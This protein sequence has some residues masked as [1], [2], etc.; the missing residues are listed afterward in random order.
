MNRKLVEDMSFSQRWKE[1]KSNNRGSSLALVITIMAIVGILAAVLLSVSLATF[2]MKQT[3]MGSQKNFYDAESVMDDIRVGL[4]QYVADAAGAA[5]TWTL[6]NYSNSN[7]NQRKTNY[8]LKFQEELLKRIQDPSAG[9]YSQK[10]DIAKLDS[11]VSPAVK[12]GAKNASSVDIP[13]ISSADGNF[14][15]NQDVDAGTYTIK[16]LLVRYVDDREYMTEIR[17]D[18]VLSCPKI[19]FTQKKTE[20]QELSTYVMVAND[21]TVVRGGSIH[22]TGNAYLG[23][24]G[25]DFSVGEVEFSPTAVNGGG[26]LVTSGQLYARNGAKVNV[27]VGYS[28]WAHE[29]Y[30]D[31]AREVSVNGSIYLNDDL[32]ISNSLGTGEVKVNLGGRLYAYGNALT[33]GNADAFMMNSLMMQDLMDHPANYSSAILINGRN[34]TLDMSNLEDM[35]IAGNAYVAAGAEDVSNSD[36]RMGE[37][38]A[39]KAS[40]R[41]YL[42]PAG[43]IAPYCMHGGMNPMSADSYNALQEEMRDLLGYGSTTDI[44]ELDYLRSSANAQ[45]SVPTELSTKYHVTGIRRAVYQVATQNGT[46]N[47]VYFFLIF[48]SEQDA[49]KYADSEFANEK[50]LKSMQVRVDEDHY[51]TNIVYPSELYTE[52]NADTQDPIADFRFYYNGSIL[53]PEN[54]Q[55]TKTKIVSGQCTRLNSLPAQTLASQAKGYQNTFAALSHYLVSDYSQLD[56]TQRQSELYDNLIYPMAGFTGTEGVKKNIA[57]GS[58]KVFSTGTAGIAP[59]S[60]M[61]ALVVNGN[62]T[63]TGTGADAYETVGTETLPVHLLIASGDVTVDC[64]FQG[65]IIAGGKVTFSSKALN[66]SADSNMVQQALRIPNADGVCAVD[67]LI[68]GQS[69]LIDTTG[70][71]QNTYGQINYS[72]YVTYSNWT[73]Q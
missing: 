35:I 30:V 4:Q 22:V 17:T 5:Y 13:M 25:T 59:E 20:V 28:T 63:L 31:S 60:Q 26:K 73:K 34:A 54:T 50:N 16:N 46:M 41:A 56:A 29:I 69:Y 23:N 36:V 65:L 3:Y 12:S 66:V 33:A 61:C 71:G 70:T 19:D 2:R 32:V 67:Y 49:M 51:R 21:Q 7:E 1:R 10:Y 40:Q 43:L 72:D 27:N 58:K 53:V 24:N 68:N 47:M 64:N 52:M 42:V 37:S 44:Q 57:P 38:I 18:I 45:P 55:Q 9:L 15:L 14:S 11:L 48:A 8:L 6:E 39:L 62:Y